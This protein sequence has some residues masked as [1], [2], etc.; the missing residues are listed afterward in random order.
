MTTSQADTTLTIVAEEIQSAPPMGMT[1]RSRTRKHRSSETARVKPPAK[2]Q[3]ESRSSEIA[4]RKSSQEQP[5][6]PSPFQRGDFTLVAPIDQESTAKDMA[7][8]EK[9]HPYKIAGRKGKGKSRKAPTGTY[10]QLEHSAITGAF[11]HFDSHAVMD[12]HVERLSAPGEG[13]GR[14]LEQ[15]PEEFKAFAKL[16][17]AF[18][19]RP[20][21]VERMRAILDFADTLID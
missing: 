3:I 21:N 19:A 4:P 15:S 18:G 1:L 12:V 13:L 17:V 8:I 9:Y 2:P 7:R 6:K 11:Q 16:P 20:N 14:L 10:Q 5:F